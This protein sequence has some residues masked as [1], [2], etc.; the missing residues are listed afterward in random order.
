[1]RIDQI[2]PVMDVPVT[3]SVVYASGGSDDHLVKLDEGTTFVRLPVSGPVRSLELNRD[4]QALVVIE[5]GP[6]PRTR[7]GD[8]VSNSQTLQQ[9]KPS[10]N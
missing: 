10:R 8:P 4:D 3:V 6:P 7:T 2:G 1:V 5:R 9:T